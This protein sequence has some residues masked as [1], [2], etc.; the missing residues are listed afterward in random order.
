MST[1][2]ERI[3]LEKTDFEESVVAYLMDNPNFFEEHTELLET[4]HLP[5]DSGPAISLVERQIQLLR[6]RNRKLERRLLDLVQVARDNETLNRQMH[7]FALILLDSDQLDTLLGDVHD[8]LRRCF[9][10]DCVALRLLGD[11]EQ[12]LHFLA[13]DEPGLA[14]LENFFK[15]GIPLCGRLSGEQLEVLF[16]GCDVTPVK[17]AVAV[18]LMDGSDRLG[19]LSMGSQDPGRFQPG[20]G[21]LFLEQLGQL[22]SRALLVHLRG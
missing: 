11:R 2:G 7:Q 17:S 14:S 13:R 3:R 8:H 21:T 18:P 19:M 5:H 6:E 10:A 15:R 4:L 1:S 16:A 22:I 20:M 12:G 9:E